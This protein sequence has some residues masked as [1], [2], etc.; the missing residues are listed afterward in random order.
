MSALSFLRSHASLAIY[1][2]KTKKF[3]FEI[4]LEILS[5]TIINSD[6]RYTKHSMLDFV[7]LWMI[8]RVGQR[9]IKIFPTNRVN[10][11]FKS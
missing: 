7:S 10:L 2:A 11:Y 9:I 6:D 4:R 1:I 5:R 3:A 8:A